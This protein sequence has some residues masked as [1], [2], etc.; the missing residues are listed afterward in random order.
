MNL[1]KNKPINEIIYFIDINPYNLRYEVYPIE[2]KY[3]NLQIHKFKSFYD[4]LK[5]AQT[6]CNNL[7]F[8]IDLY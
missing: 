4:N 1:K 8:N 3:K 5:T 7:N 6:I 2:S